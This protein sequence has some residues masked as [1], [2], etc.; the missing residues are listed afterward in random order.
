[1]ASDRLL[2]M[3]PLLKASET[4]ASRRRGV[5]VTGGGQCGRLGVL[6]LF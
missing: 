2:K 6:M 4:L 1:M 3:G 5:C